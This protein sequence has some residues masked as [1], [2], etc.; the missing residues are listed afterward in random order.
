MKISI[1]L[2]AGLFIANFC[3]VI[4]FAQT[5]RGGISGTVFDKNGGVIPGATV[6]ITNI[7]TNQSQKLT[8]SGEGAYAAISLDPVAY[9]ITVEAPGFKKIVLNNVKVDTA[10][11]VTV[12]VTLETGA[13]E[14]I[15]DVT[16][17]TPL[18]NTASGATTQTITARQT[19]DIPLNNRSVLDLAVTLPNVS[20]DAG[21]ED[22]A[23]TSGQPVPGFNL[24][25]N[26]GRPGSTIFLADGVNNT[27]VGIARTVVSFTPETVQEFTVQTSVYSAEFGQTGGGVINVTTKSGTNEYNGEALWYHRNPVTNAGP[28]V[29]GRGPRTPVSLRYNQMS[30]TFGGP[31]WLPKKVFGPAGY[32]GHDKTFFFFAYEPRYR[33]DFITTTTLLPTAAE[34]AGDFSNL[35]RTASGWLPVSVAQQFGQASVG[36]ITD[37]F[38]QFNRDASGRLIPITPG[39]GQTYPQFP[40]NRIPQELIDPIAVKLLQ[41]MPQ[42]GDYFIDNAGL[43]RNYIVNRFVRQDET[44]YT[45]RLD[46]SISN[47]NKINFRLT[48]T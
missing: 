43:V 15:I 3:A 17:E 22:P 12:N 10:T 41:F 11:T 33:R 5:N 1:R 7:G 28:Y 35:V 34:R 20:G 39:A 46:H 23:V 27:G 29:T 2:L 4:V 42:G 6:T 47:A 30:L 26:G 16:A 32:D 9:R 37:I 19:Q 44:R 25:L 8:T 40:G 14:T 18:L 13:V 31:I 21:S 38:R 24:S 36:G 48:T 45:L